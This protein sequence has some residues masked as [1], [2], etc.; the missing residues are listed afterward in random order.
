MMGTDRSFH[1]KASDKSAQGAIRRVALGQIDSALDE[2]GNSDL[3]S[4]KI[5]HQVRKRCK[6]VR[7]L[8]RL[9][10]PGFAEYEH[11]NASFRDLART[12]GGFRDQDVLIQT[13]D[14]IMA[15]YVKDA[16]D[17]AMA[18]VR[19]RL[20]ADRRQLDPGA[21]EEIF[22]AFRSGMTQARQRVQMWVVEGHGYA[23]FSGGLAQVLRRAHKAMDEAKSHAMPEPMHEWRKAVKYHGYHAR[24]LRE[25]WPEAMLSNI[26]LTSQLAELL[27]DYH[28]LAVLQRSLAEQPEH[29][30]GVEVTRLIGGLADRRKK[31]LA[32][33]AFRQ[34]ALLFA[35]RPTALA[36]RWGCYWQI[37]RGG[38]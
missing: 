5:V 11:E 36:R 18:C 2:I 14:K 13:C 7:A 17:D 21:P 25:I 34:G 35:E 4:E 12:L 37:W 6:K 19:E 23:A 27:G 28:D 31:E 16:D 10:R 8:I 24:L 9:V 3:T 29:Y 15:H 26:T 22:A 20:V 32:Q 33:D 30:G 1:F 38:D